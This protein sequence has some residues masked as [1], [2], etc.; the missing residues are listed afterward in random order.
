MHELSIAKSIADIVIAQAEQ[1]QAQRIVCVRLR[2]GDLTAI[3]PEALRFSFDA[4]TRETCAEN[5]RLEIE[6]IPWMVECSK[7]ACEYPVRED[8]PIC[9]QCEHIGGKTISGRELQIVE[10]DIE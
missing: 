2:V 8:I 7:C 5:A 10:M 1:S 4:V 9:P 3:V 6:A